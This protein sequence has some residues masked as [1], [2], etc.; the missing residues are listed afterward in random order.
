MFKTAYFHIGSSKTGTSVIQNG[1][2]NNIDLLAEAGIFYPIVKGRDAANTVVATG[3]GRFFMNFRDSKKTRKIPFENAYKRVLKQIVDMTPKNCHSILFSSEGFAGFDVDALFIFKEHL[4]KICENFK[5]IYYV[6]HPLDQSVSRYMEFFKKNKV[7]SSGKDEYI[8]SYDY[9][10]G[11]YLKVN[12][13]NYLSTIKNY[14]EV[15]GKENVIVKLYDAEKGKLYFDF[16][17][18]IGIQDTQNFTSPEIMN[19]SLTLKEL[20]VMRQVNKHSLQN[21]QLTKAVTMTMHDYRP[22]K[23]PFFVTHE[24]V[25]LAEGIFKETLDYF[26]EHHFSD[27]Q[28]KLLLKSPELPIGPREA[29]T[30]S[31]ETEFLRRILS[32]YITLTKEG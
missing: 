25:H 28:H 20:E 18:T 29:I 10:F 1:N 15:F 30:L 27:T 4:S 31:D 26:N 13:N 23:D 9:D 2:M 22:Q 17:N 32:N 24:E 19:R 21:G 12:R 5:I 11:D 6:R 16:L 3:N 7:L 8:N 14:T